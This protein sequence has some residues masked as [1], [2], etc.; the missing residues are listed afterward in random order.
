[1]HYED[2]NEAVQAGL[3]QLLIQHHR[4]RLHVGDGGDRP[5][6]KKLMGRR[7]QVAPRGI[8]LAQVF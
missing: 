4:R 8:L 2:A 6:A 3:Y 5:T 7:P 1:M